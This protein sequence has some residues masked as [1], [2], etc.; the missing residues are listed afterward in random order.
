MAKCSVGEDG[1]Y[2]CRGGKGQVPGFRL[3]GTAQRDPSWQLY[4]KLGDPRLKSSPE[5][6]V[7]ATGN[8]G[9][10]GEGTKTQDAGKFLV[11]AQEYRKAFGPTQAMSL[12]DHLGL[13]TYALEALP[14][15][16]WRNVDRD[17]KCWIFPEWDGTGAICGLVRRYASG[18]K[19]AIQG[20]RR[21]LTLPKDWGSVGGKLYVPAGASDTLA[22]HVLGLDAIGRPNDTACVDDLA[23]I[24]ATW[25]A[26]RGICILGENDPKPDGTWPGLAGCQTAASQLAAKL[27]RQVQWALPPDRAKDARAWVAD[28]LSPLTSDADIDPVAQRFLS[29]LKPVR[30]EPS[31]PVEKSSLVT[32]TLDT[33]Q[34]EVIRWI[35]EPYLP[36]ATLALLAGDGKMGKSFLTLTIAAQLSLGKPCFGMLSPDREPIESLIFNREDTQ[37]RTLKPRL[38]TLGADFA[39]IHFV[40]GVLNDKGKTVQFSLAEMLQLRSHLIANPRIRFVVID[41]VDS[42]ISST[43]VDDFRAASLRDLI[44]DPLRD[45][46]RLTGALILMILHLSK[47]TSPKAIHRIAN[48]MG[49]YNGSRVA[50]MAFPEPG[51]K[52]NRVFSCEKFNDYE[53]PTSLLYRISKAGPTHCDNILASMTGQMSPEDLQAYRKQLAFAEWVGETPLDGDAC[54]AADAEFVQDDPNDAERAAR[55]LRSY[56]A[57]GPRPAN[58]CETDGNKACSM[59]HDGRWWREKVLKR[60]V[61][62]A[63]KKAGFDGGWVWS[64]AGDNRQALITPENVEEAEEAEEVRRSEEAHTP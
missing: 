34:D 48:S 47:S 39:K 10:K 51:S 49:Y 43:G 54:C 5:R 29:S 62:G 23:Q 64:L 61:N 12:A 32:V 38:R 45:I 57:N 1:L 15:L 7:D 25:P 3:L 13:P 30:V 36:E 41:P 18:M 37:G 60:R 50:Y 35:Q 52:I 9:G 40:D 42:Y 8:E 14:L 46:A 22:L 33:V 28:A 17:G 56:L 19:K 16:G 44:L 55:W 4:R 58:S 27:Q 59:D 2:M 26:D 31:K 63:Y 21:G 6:G 11:Q 20:S 53:E 24:L